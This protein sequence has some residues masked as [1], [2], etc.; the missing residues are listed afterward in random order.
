MITI[1]YFARY[2]ELLGVVAETYATAEVPDFATLKT[3]I[4]KRHPEAIAM[5]QDPRCIVALNQQVVTGDVVFKSGDEVAFFPP[6]S[7]G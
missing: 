7:G 4:A 6:V 3:V 1:K 2:R 5:L